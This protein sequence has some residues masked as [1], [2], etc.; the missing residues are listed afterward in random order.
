MGAPADTRAGRPGK[1]PQAGDTTAPDDIEGTEPLFWALMLKFEG[2]ALERYSA[3]TPR[4]ATDEKRSFVASL[5]ALETDE[6]SLAASVLA[7][8]VEELVAR[9]RSTNA[10]S[11]LIVQGLVLEHLGQAIYRVAAETERASPASRA[12]AAA[13]CAASRSVTTEASAE[14]AA[15]VGTADRLYA[16]FADT[17][18][19]VLAALDALAEPVDEVFGERFGLR[20]A[21]VM[22]EFA[23]G[24]VTA[25]TA[26]GMQRRKVVAH[27]AGA[28]MGL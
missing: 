26:L 12:L 3:H 13:G 4:L 8:P 24:L 11:A 27:L 6:A 21:D 1:T 17:S 19:H 2:L 28:C 25:C 10:V 9:A 14:I 7:P 5:H 22:G 18:E 23:A 20:F 15:H 16:V